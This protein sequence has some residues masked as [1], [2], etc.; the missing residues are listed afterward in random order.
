MTTDSAGRYQNKILTIPNILSFFRLCLIPV[1]VW[2]YVGKQD[3]LWTLLILTLSGVTDIVDG[4]IARKYN[5]ISNFGKAFDPIADKLTQMA[6]LFCLVSRFKYMT[7]PL[8]L[9]VIKEVVTGIT[10][11]VSIKRTGTVKGAVWHGKLTT[12][13]LYSM[14]AIHIVWF[15]IPHA[16][17]LILVGVCIGIMLMSFIMYSIQNIKAIK[18]KTYES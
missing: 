4:I 18:N 1:I 5:M 17:S 2:L 14:M 11:L 16:I 8:V 13:S 15:N 3:Y 9:L 10:S 12:V 7:V 6:M